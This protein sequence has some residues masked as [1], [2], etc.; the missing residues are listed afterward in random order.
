MAPIL[1]IVR[2]AEAEHN[3]DARYHL[4]DPKLTRRG[5]AQCGILSSAEKDLQ[6]RVTHLVASPSSRAVETCAL[7]FPAVV[8]R[9]KKI[10][11]LG[12]LVEV[13]PYHCN[14]PADIETLQR[15]FGD[16][17]EFKH[18]D[19]DYLD[20]SALSRY[21]ATPSALEQRAR[22]A[23]R[24]LSALAQS[25]GE[26]AE[27]VV[28]SH[29]GF[30][31]WLV[32]DFD[33][34]WENAELDSFRFNAASPAGIPSLSRLNP[35][36]PR[37]PVV[38]DKLDSKGS[39]KQDEP[40]MMMPRML[41]DADG[42][43]VEGSTTCGMKRRRDGEPQDG[44]S[45]PVCKKPRNELD[46]PLNDVW[47]KEDDR[48]KGEDA[49]TT[50]TKH[51]RN[52]EPEDDIPTPTR[53]KSRNELDLPSSYPAPLGPRQPV[54]VEIDPGT[55]KF[56][57]H[58]FSKTMLLRA[59][60]IQRYIKDFP[61]D[62][63]FSPLNIARARA[64]QPL[65]PGDSELVEETYPPNWARLTRSIPAFLNLHWNRCFR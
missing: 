55:I 14:V 10:I 22:V 35:A 27:I 42:C 25:H 1:H 40:P 45:E 51:K 43:K 60:Q 17:V 2:H 31:Q 26:D 49:P 20:R 4:E 48:S 63:A 13:E 53:K 37:K 6:K 57:K 65:D 28:V 5:K 36:E 9:G 56:Q 24:I 59:R 47:Q 38:W 46:D 8:E 16:L 62:D 18:L 29:G 61:D 7:A 32:E 12:E 21:A 54:S 11:L 19:A 50:G 52:D 33:T 34:T 3:V 44:I 39:E 23:R 30:I 41:G 64:V 58:R 15:E